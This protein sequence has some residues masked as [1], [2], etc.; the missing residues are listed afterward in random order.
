[1]LI[2]TSTENRRFPGAESYRLV[3]VEVVQNDAGSRDARGRGSGTP[4]VLSDGGQQRV[5]VWVMAR[6]EVPTITFVQPDA[7]RQDDLVSSQ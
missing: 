7:F 5:V 3:A 4:A 2:T 1:M 6:D